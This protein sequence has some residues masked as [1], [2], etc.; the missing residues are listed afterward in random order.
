MKRITLLFVFYALSQVVHSQIWDF[1]GVK[2]LS[3]DVNSASEESLPIFSKDSS[4]LYFI[5]TFDKR[6]KGGELDQDIWMSYRQSNG[7]Y[8]GSKQLSSMNTKYNNGVVGLS[9]DGQ[10]LYLLNTYEGKKDLEKGVAIARRKGSGW[11]TPEKV[12][13]PTLDIEGDYYGFHISEDES[14]LLISYQGPGTVGEED[15]YVSLRSGESWSAPMN[16]GSVIN[17]P[18]FE[19]SPFLSKGKDT[20]FFSSNGHGGYG[21]ADIFYSV[22]G[23]SWTDWSKPV[24]LGSKINSSKFD[25]CFS[26]SGNQVYWSSNRDTEKSD[27][28]TAYLVFPPPIELSCSATNATFYQGSNGRI[29]LDLKG[30][31]APFTYAWSNGSTEKNLVGVVKGEYSVVVTDSYGQTA[32]ATCMVDEPAPVVFEPVDVSTWKNL[33][34]MHYFDYNKNKLTVSRGD[35]KKFVKEVEA[36]LKDGREKI[37]INVYSSASKVPTKTYETNENLTQIRAEN[38]KYDLS[39]YFESK[40]EFAGKVN[41]VIVSAIVDGPDYTGDAK[42]VKKYRPYQFVGLKTE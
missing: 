17:T 30:G 7:D 41:V 39:T 3:G 5:R 13:V 42:D 19:M 40:K 31:A 23:N 18:G 25:V 32:I 11:G 8:S 24:N 33:E 6:N 9:G 37:T 12:E 4:I 26:Y 27:I 34:F 35:L 16:I 36:Q 1:D 21:D 10:S 28:Y 14:V 29:D 20:L 2:K 22:R 38:M 15:I